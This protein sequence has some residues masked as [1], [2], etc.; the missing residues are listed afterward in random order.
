LAPEA[1]GKKKIGAVNTE[2]YREEGEK[3][4]FQKEL[5]RAKRA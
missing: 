1:Q 5:T 3:K 4:G 2:E